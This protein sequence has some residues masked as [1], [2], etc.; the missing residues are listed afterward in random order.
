MPFYI[1]I[2]HSD[3][4]PMARV[5]Q[6]CVDDTDALKTATHLS[7]DYNIDVWRGAHVVAELP[8]IGTRKEVHGTSV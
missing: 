4:T 2:F 3:D 7:R 5:E 1:F 8:K 6:E